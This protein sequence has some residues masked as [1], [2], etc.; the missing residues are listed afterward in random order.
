MLAKTFERVKRNFLISNTQLG[1]F[2]FS[3]YFADL[4]LLGH[5]LFKNV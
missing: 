5:A 4:N 2:K 1:F 3:K